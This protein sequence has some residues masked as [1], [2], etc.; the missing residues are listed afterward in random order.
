M[1]NTIEDILEV[2]KKA[3]K[4]KEVFI[5]DENEEYYR[6][7]KLEVD[8]DGDLIINVTANY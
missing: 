4:N 6:I 1:I 8:E 7:T 3:D 2:C 5:K